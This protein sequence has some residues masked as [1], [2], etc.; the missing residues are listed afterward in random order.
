MTNDAV[1]SFARRSTLATNSASRRL[2]LLL[3]HKSEASALTAAV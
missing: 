3:L 2:L 1:I